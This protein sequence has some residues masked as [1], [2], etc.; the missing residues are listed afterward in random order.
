ME[1]LPPVYL[2]AIILT[3]FAIAFSLRGPVLRRWVLTAPEVEQSKRQFAAEVALCLVAA[4]LAVGYN[5]VVLN[6]PA[7]SG[8]SL[9]LG[10]L[11]AGFFIGIDMALHRERRIILEARRQSRNLKPPARYYSITR[12]F[13]LVAVSTTLFVTIVIILVI[14]RD[15]VWLSRLEQSQSAYNQATLSVAYEIFFIMG[16]LLAAVVNLILS[17][18]GN[19][20]ILFENETGVLERVSRGDLSQTVPVAT[21]DEFGVIA[22]HTNHMIAGLQHRFELIAALKLA[23]EV[24]KNL[25]PAAPPSIPGLDLAGTSIYCDETGGDY[26][27][28]LPLNGGRLGVVVADASGHGVGAALHMT[29]ARAFLLF[30]VRNYT[31][32]AQLLGDVNRYLTRDSTQ[33][34]RFMSVFFLEIA[35]RARTL[36]WVRAGHDPAL[37]FDPRTDQFRELTGDGMALGVQGDYEF[38]ENKLEAWRPGQ[39]IVIGTDGL[40]ETRNA[41]GEMFGQSRLREIIRRHGRK[42]AAGIKDAVIS[43]IEEFRGTTPQED[44]VTLV[45]VRLL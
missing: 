29:T 18:S 22:G 21:R 16:A 41:A 17:Y 37:L 43:S 36:R 14:S 27:D 19:L 40:H 2:G 15:I 32:P 44:D 24:Q 1:S 25:L 45:V 3:A 4:A 8:I 23:E 7:P 34:S 20:K 28:Y 33:T 38:R 6:F 11:V 5:T 13:S 26:Y 35:P 10:C 12:R 9:A 39:I 42:P 30:G 31:G